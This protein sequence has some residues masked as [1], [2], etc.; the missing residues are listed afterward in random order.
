MFC[1]MMCT[2]YHHL[3]RTKTIKN[4]NLARFGVRTAV[5]TK[6]QIFWDVKL[7]LLGHSYRRFEGSYFC[8]LHGLTLREPR[9]WRFGAP[10]LRQ[11]LAAD[12]VCHTQQLHLLYYFC[13]QIYHFIIWLWE[14]SYFSREN[15]TDWICL[16]G[17][18]GVSW[19]EYVYL[20]VWERKRQETRNY[21]AENLH[22]R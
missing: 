11:Y 13:A 14:S 5:L 4:V 19:W 7:C 16:I 17:W 18:G 6:C 22:D 20:D 10:K 1:T 12:T 21:H 3:H 8:H 9:R 2:R 15:A